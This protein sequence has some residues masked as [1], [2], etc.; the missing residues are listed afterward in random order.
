M[1]NHMENTTIFHGKT[2]NFY[3]HFPQLCI[4]RWYTRIQ[5][6]V[7]KQIVISFIVSLMWFFCSWGFKNVE[8]S[9]PQ[10][11]VE[12]VQCTWFWSD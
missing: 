2:H 11:D 8:S 7:N 5:K 12:K 4:A 9:K 6:P 10:N 1:E 3:G